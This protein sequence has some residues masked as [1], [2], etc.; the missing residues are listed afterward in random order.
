MI[1]YFM[2]SLKRKFIGSI[3]ITL[4]GLFFIT[5]IVA[6]YLQNNA[7][8]NLLTASGKVVDEMFAGQT[9]TSS[10]MEKNQGRSNS[11]T[12][13]RDRSFSDCFI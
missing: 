6:L 12:I 10:E 13:V 2:A 3:T 1:N 8:E 4:F 7:L 5:S 11:K 9:Q